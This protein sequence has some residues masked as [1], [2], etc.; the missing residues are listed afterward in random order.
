LQKFT[1]NAF[2]KITQYHRKRNYSNTQLTV[3]IKLTST[4]LL[5]VDQSQIN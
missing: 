4:V 3:K 2:N 5:A 1:A